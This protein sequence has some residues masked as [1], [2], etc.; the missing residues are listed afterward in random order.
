MWPADRAFA[1]DFQDAF[2]P[3]RRAHHGQP[4]RHR[5]R[6]ADAALADARQLDIQLVVAGIYEVTED[7]NLGAG[8]ISVDLDARDHLNAQPLSCGLGLG[9]AR[10]GV[11]V[12]DGDDLD[13]Q[14]GRA[15]HQLLR[16]V[17]PVGCGRV[18]VQV[19]FIH[20]LGALG[21]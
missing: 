17:G 6:P 8:H 21:Q 5:A 11:V 4:L 15:R 14:L 20:T 19:D 3:H 12:G 13:S 18:G 1:R 7:V 10:G 2:E 9:H 16:S